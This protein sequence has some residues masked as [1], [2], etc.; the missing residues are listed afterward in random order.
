DVECDLQEGAVQLTWTA[1]ADDGAYALSGPGRLYD[2]RYSLAPITDANW[3]G[4]T[5]FTAVPNPGTPG[6]S[7]SVRVNGLQPTTRYYFR[8]KTKDDRS[9]SGNWSALSYPEGSTTTKPPRLC[10]RSS[11]ARAA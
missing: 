5:S 11:P 1:A 2:V 3:N 7:E 8:L 9:G 6:T 4:A 10:A